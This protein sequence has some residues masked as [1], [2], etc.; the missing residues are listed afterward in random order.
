[1]GLLYGCA[2]RLNTKNAGFW[3]GQFWAIAA[4]DKTA[5]LDEGLPSFS[6]PILVYMDN[7]Y[8]DKNLQ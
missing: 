7:P 4:F 1:M 3:P 6:L 8:M 5:G 2:G